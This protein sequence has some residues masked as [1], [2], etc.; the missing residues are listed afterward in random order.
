[1]SVPRESTSGAQQPPGERDASATDGLVVSYMTLRKAIGVLGVAL[2]V[3]LVA[4]GL[5]LFGGHGLQPTISDYYGTPM[6]DG[7]GGL[8]FAIGLF[9]FS[10]RGFNWRDELAG[11]IACAFAVGVALFP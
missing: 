5:I 9:L 11:K 7:F 6:G 8:L 3:V 10:Y 4:G 1:M 2:P